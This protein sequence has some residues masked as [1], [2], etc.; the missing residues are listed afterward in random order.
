M[1]VVS[2]GENVPVN[3]ID[4]TAGTGTEE[5][6]TVDNN[7]QNPDTV[8]G[9][10]VE[11]EGAKGG[12]PTGAELPEGVTPEM[13]KEL[14]YASDKDYKELQREFGSRT[15]ADKALQNRFSQYGGMETSEEMLAFLHGNPEFA[16]WMKDQQETRLYGK[17]ADEIDPQTKEAMELVKKIAGEEIDKAMKE[18]VDPLA[19]SYKEGL[20]KTNMAKMNDKYPQWMELKDTMANLGETLPESIQDNPSFKDLESL[21]IRALV[22]DGKINDFGKNIYE[23][24]LQSAKAKNVAKP[25]SAKKGTPGNAK[26]MKE[27]YKMAKEQMKS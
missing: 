19:S 16:K 18:Q 7:E 22:E 2:A 3:S 14:G 4:G 12:E 11:K 25:S 9:Q 24:D 20:L 15:E 27:A 10:P 23:K 6:Q 17:P 8:E 26:S 13:L 5:G 21:Y 1:S